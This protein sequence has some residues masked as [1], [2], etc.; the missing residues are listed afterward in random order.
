MFHFDVLTIDCASWLSQVWFSASECWVLNKM[1]TKKICNFIFLWSLSRAVHYKEIYHQVSQR[2]Q[3]KS[4]SLG[5]GLVVYDFIIYILIYKKKQAKN[6]ATKKG[7]KSILL[8]LSWHE[9]SIRPL[10]WKRKS[11]LVAIFHPLHSSWKTQCT[12]S[13]FLAVHF[14]SSHSAW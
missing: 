9:I 3:D 7:Q 13:I 2:H 8:S 4:P 11:A 6:F 14:F 1:P 5:I 10:S 12:T